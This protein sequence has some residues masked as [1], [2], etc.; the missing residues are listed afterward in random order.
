MSNDLKPF[1]AEANSIK[2]DGEYEHFKGNRYK[3]LAVARDSD[4]LEELVV[5]VGQYDDNPVWTRPVNDFLKEV[6]KPDYKGPRFK[7]VENN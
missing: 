5:Y 3:V 6:D 2:L 4:T 1:S 7:L